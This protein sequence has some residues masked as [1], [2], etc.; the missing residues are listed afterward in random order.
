MQ[1]GEAFN[2]HEPWKLKEG[3]S[4]FLVT[5]YDKVSVPHNWSLDSRYNIIGKAWYRKGFILPNI[6]KDK[7][8]RLHFEAVFSKARIFINGKLA[9]YHEGG[10]TPFTIDITKYVNLTEVNFISVEVNNSWDE[11]S[12]P[13]SKVAEGGNA[14]IF[15]WYEF[16]GITRDVSLIVTNN[17]FI[18]NQKIEAS[19]NINSGKAAVKIY[20]WLEN[21]SY[22]DKNIVVNPIITNRTTGKQLRFANWQKEILVKA[23]TKQLVEINLT[24]NK[25]DV[26]LWDFDNPNLYDVKTSLSNNNTIINEFDTYFGIRSFKSVGTQLLLNGKPIRVAGA[27]RPSDH[28]VY[29]ATDPDTLAKIDMGLMRNGH[30]IFSRLSHTPLGRSI[31]KWADEHGYLI[32]AELTNW[33]ISPVQMTNQRVKD[34]A[35]TQMKEMVESFW[36]SPSIVAYSS[37]NEYASWTPEGDEWTRYTM[38]KFRELDTTRLLTFVALGTAASPPNLKLPHNSFRY[39]DFLNFNNYSNA[40]GLIKNIENI[41]AQFPDKPIFVS[42]TGV[43]SDEVRSESDRIKHLDGVIDAVRKKPYVAGFAY[44]TFNDYLSRY[45]NTNKNGYRPWGIVDANRKPRD[46]YKAFQSKLSPVL[47]SIAK[48]KITITGVSDFPSYTL[49]NHVLRILV[50]NKII[51]TRPLPTIEPGKTVELKVEKLPIKC[52]IIIENSGGVIISTSIF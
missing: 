47:V 40:E 33:Q 31:Y 26:L 37:G 14:E 3:D 17:I 4:T 21:K 6:T 38:E 25:E 39:C 10:Y 7:I 48:D 20:T 42:E 45:T 27:N 49:T 8:I 16:G 11:F 41:H 44:W 1:K 24:L 28:P 51:S 43:R 18:Q 35:I 52:S 2:W 30:M 50:D 13:G 12:F 23:F 34:A 9:G 29:G 22:D 32:I 36:N 46:L 15:P 19:P 5:G